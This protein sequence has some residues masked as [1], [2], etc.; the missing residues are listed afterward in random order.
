MDWR[1]NE[2]YPD[3]TAAEAM[4]RVMGTEDPWAHDELDSDG[5]HALIDTVARQAVEDYAAALR[6]SGPAA[7]RKQAE[8]ESFFRS[9]YF[10]RLTGMDGL[11][12]IRMV[13]KVVERE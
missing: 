13:R 1:N 6:R 10:R 5:C 2:H 11:R 9:E 8:A 4:A 12:I 7:L 3:T